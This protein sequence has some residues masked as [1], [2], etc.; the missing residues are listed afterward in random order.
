MRGMAIKLVGVPGKKVLEHNQDALTHDFLLVTTKT[1]QTRSVRDFQKSLSALMGGGLKLIWY[2]LTHPMVI[3]RSIKQISKC[4]NLLE[5]SFFS[6]TPYRFGTDQHLAVKYAVVPSHK[7]QSP[8]PEKPTA[9]FLKDR[10]IND[11]A[12][13]EFHFD[14]MVQFQKEPVQMPIED[15]TIEWTSPFIK[16]AT[17]QIPKQVFSSAEQEAYGQNL[18][19]TPWHC[20]QEHQPLGGVNRARKAV[21]IALSAFRHELN[22]KQESEPT[23]MESFT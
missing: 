20:I 2:A 10:L 23:A 7:Q 1:L 9:D 15:P 21:Y 8:M 14:F 22:G 19:F 17:I 11:L 3:I 13:N 18:S 5:T 4:S 6:T 16:V 12:N